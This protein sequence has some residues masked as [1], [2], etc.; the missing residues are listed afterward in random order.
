MPSADDPGNEEL[1]SEAAGRPHD[2]DREILKGIQITG[3]GEASVGEGRA[4]P[5]RRALGACGGRPKVMSIL[6]LPSSWKPWANEGHTPKSL[7]R[8]LFS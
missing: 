3:G 5:K 4:A 2:D 7:P 8:E 1:V 6:E